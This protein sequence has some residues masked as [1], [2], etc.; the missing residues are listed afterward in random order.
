MIIISILV[1]NMILRK[2]LGFG[3]MEHPLHLQTGK[4]DILKM[5]PNMDRVRESIIRIVMGFPDALLSGSIC[6]VQQ[7]LQPKDILLFAKP[8]VYHV[9]M[10]QNGGGVAIWK[11]QH[12]LK[13]FIFYHGYYYYI[14]DHYYAIYFNTYFTN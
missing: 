2:T 14:V 5:H 6:L 4:Q 9:F 8:L 1:F 13:F 3:A 11:L 7:Q 12:K 10:V